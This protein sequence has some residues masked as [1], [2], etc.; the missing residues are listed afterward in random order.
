M[1]AWLVE[2][3]QD[4]HFA[5]LRAVGFAADCYNSPLPTSERLHTS[6]DGLGDPQHLPCQPAEEETDVSLLP[7]LTFLASPLLAHPLVSTARNLNF[8]FLTHNFRSPSAA[9]QLQ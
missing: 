7:N 3:N 2:Y 4:P 8:A 6:R 9:P 5:P 1:Q